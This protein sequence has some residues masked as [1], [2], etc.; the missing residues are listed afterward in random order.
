MNL[1]DTYEKVKPSI[2]AFTLRRCL[3]ATNSENLN[4][5]QPSFPPILGTGFIIDKKGIIATND[6]VAEKLEKPAGLSSFPNS[7]SCYQATIFKITDGGLIAIPLEIWEVC[8]PKKRRKTKEPFYGPDKPDIAFVT[9]KAKDLPALELDISELKEGTEVATAGFPMGRVL[10]TAPGW[11]HQI[12]PTLQ[13]GIISALLPFHQAVPHAYAINIMIQSGASGSPVFLP[14]NGKVIGIMDSSLN[15]PAKNEQG[16][17]YNIP[18]N[19]SYATPSY[20][21]A[22]FFKNVEAKD[23]FE[24]PEDAETFA[25]IIANIIKIV[26]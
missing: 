2:V 17:K 4:N 10:L 13:K 16:D 19:I 25:D 6:H 26:E 24:L 22:K 20:L 23:P 9:V 12:G 8:R 18:T 5:D 14:E 21:I 3:T 15:N 11:L 7:E 1:S